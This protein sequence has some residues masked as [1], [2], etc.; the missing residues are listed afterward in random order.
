MDALLTLGLLP[1]TALSLAGVPGLLD[2][3]GS[4]VV[5][6]TGASSSPAHHAASGD[7][8]DLTPVGGIGNDLAGNTQPGGLTPRPATSL[9][10]TR[11]PGT[12]DWAEADLVD[13]DCTRCV[14]CEGEGLAWLDGEIIPCPD[15]GGRPHGFVPDEDCPDCGG[16]G[17]VVAL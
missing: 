1:T 15:C 10:R 5:V 11:I 8:P 7:R 2:P 14:E 13:C 16:H 9:V 4:P 17:K 6:T 12:D 3:A